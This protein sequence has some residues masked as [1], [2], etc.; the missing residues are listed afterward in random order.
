MEREAEPADAGQRTL[1]RIFQGVEFSLVHKG[2]QVRCLAS[3]EL[4]VRTFGA[5]PTCRQSWLEAF[6]RGQAPLRQCART[7]HAITGRSP[8][9]LLD[10]DGQLLHRSANPEGAEATVASPA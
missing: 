2:H 5:T 1:S 9:L 3:F 4:L 10:D 6:D 8:V 7:K